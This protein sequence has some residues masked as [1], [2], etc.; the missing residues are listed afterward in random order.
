MLAAA[1]LLVPAC[2]LILRLLSDMVSGETLPTPGE[3]WLLL[4]GPAVP[5]YLL[6]LPLAPFLLIAQRRGWRPRALWIVAGVTGI[7][8]LFDL[9]FRYRVGL[10]SS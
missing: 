5:V 4:F 2:V 1:P 3:A 6:V 10:L 9:A 8:V 7:G